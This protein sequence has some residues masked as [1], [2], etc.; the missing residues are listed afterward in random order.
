M[1]R[2][3]HENASPLLF[4]WTRLIR[5][6][7]L[8]AARKVFDY[9]APCR[10][11]NSRC[12]ASNKNMKWIDAVLALLLLALGFLLGAAFSSSKALGGRNT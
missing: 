3:V 5:L 7:G 12:E 9:S 6:S 2:S 4:Y 10:T 1:V 8:Q 11:N